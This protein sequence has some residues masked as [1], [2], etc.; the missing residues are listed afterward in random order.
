MKK[1]KPI[2]MKAAPKKKVVII[3][4]SNPVPA[5]VKTVAASAPVV[6]VAAPVPVVAQIAAPVAAPVTQQ[7]V[8]QPNL[9]AV[10]D[11]GTD[12]KDQK[13]ATFIDSNV[14]KAMTAS[15]EQTPVPDAKPLNTDVPSTPAPSLPIGVLKTST[16]AN[17]DLV[18]KAIQ[19]KGEDK[20]LMGA[21]QI[22]NVA[23][24]PV[25]KAAAQAKP[26][27]AKAD[28]AAEFEKA[29]IDVDEDQDE[30]SK[31]PMTEEKIQTTDKDEKDSSAKETELSKLKASVAKIESHLAKAKTALD[32]HKKIENG[33]NSL[34]NTQHGLA[35][36]EL[37]NSVKR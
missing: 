35:K 15:G 33:I 9:S 29:F 10:Q 18:A 37:M 2:V 17:E 27:S 30:G 4:K 8:A 36:K 23:V 3:K 22:K 1:L 7:V 16:T 32:N 5:P 28:L 14:V 24:S 26:A 21:S 31:P 34:A 12:R 11:P 13:V 20:K 19:N 6:A 25:K